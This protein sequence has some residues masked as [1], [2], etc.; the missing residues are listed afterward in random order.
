VLICVGATLVVAQLRGLPQEQ[1]LQK[2]IYD[3]VYYLLLRKCEMFNII[4]SISYLAFVAIVGFILFIFAAII[5]LLTVAFDKRLYILHFFT[6]I[7]G[8]LYF[9][10]MPLWSV[11]IEG[12]ENIKKKTYIVV[13]NHQSLLDI[14]VIYRIFFHFKWVSKA[15]IFKL[16]FI[17]WNMTLNRYIKLVRGDKD[18]A[19][20]MFYACNKAIAT[21]SSI[22]M[23]PEGTRSE[24]GELKSFKPG[25]FILALENKVP[26]LPIVIN[27]T[28]NALP[29][30]S[31]R[32]HGSHNIIVKVLKE[33]PYESFQHLSIEEIS[34]FVKE[35][36][37][38][39]LNELKKL[40]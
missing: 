19:R 31:L 27:G 37:L 32:F 7:W 20:S 4:F 3:N 38:N 11:Q 5:W 34:D 29:K 21:G 1:P 28:K 10:A 14:L 39:E 26:I 2:F 9:W 6:S 16:P 40:A 17:G 13:S 22:C 33:I 25:A 35:H 8:S 15:E 12:R 36:I 30:K 18:S 24:T 23:F